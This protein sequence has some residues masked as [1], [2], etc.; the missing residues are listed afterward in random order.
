M[1]R[2]MHTL[3]KNQAGMVSI[4]VVM[5]MMIV[6]SLVVVG[7]SALSSSEQRNT[8]D[9]QLSAEAFY[10]ANSGINNAKYVVEQELASGTLTNQTQCAPAG[11]PYNANAGLDAPVGSSPAVTYSCVNVITTPSNLQ[12]T[13]SH[14]QSWAFPIQLGPDGPPAPPSVTSIGFSWSNTSGNANLGC[15]A[16]GTFT[17]SASWPCSPSVLQVDLIS[18]NNIGSV[19]SQESGAYTLFLYP[20]N[21]G[22]QSGS[23]SNGAV[24]TVPC[25]AAQCTATISVPGASTYYARVTPVYTDSH[26]TITANGSSQLYDAQAQIDVTGKAQD[27][28]QRLDARVPLD[29]LASDAPLSAVQS[30][31]SICKRIEGYPGYINVSLPS[32]AGATA[33]CSP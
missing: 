31:D 24:Y 12:K 4:I 9:R 11:S 27:V 21:G 13:L 18:S 1:N 33:A 2:N 15:P 16:A 32:G 28:L 17:P 3:R 7:F 14:G 19:T 20:H 26:V 6:I 23:L 25:S 10:A 30:G 29:S 22:S 8:L 5:I